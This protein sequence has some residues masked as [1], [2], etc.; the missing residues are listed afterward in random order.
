[1]PIIYVQLKQ[2]KYFWNHF[3][4]A[5]VPTHKQQ[6]K[7]HCNFRKSRP[8]GS[9][10]WRLHVLGVTRVMSVTSRTR[11]TLAHAVKTKQCRRPREAS[12][13]NEEVFW[14]S[15]K[16]LI[17]IDQVRSQIWQRDLPNTKQLRHSQHFQFSHIHILLPHENPNWM[18][19]CLVFRFTEWL[20]VTVKL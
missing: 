8:R 13:K 20:A 3:N 4:R 18:K 7:I 16:I 10:V 19:L 1:M 17:K 5:S 12:S 2:F 11:R 6:Q 15:T 14:K 9:Y